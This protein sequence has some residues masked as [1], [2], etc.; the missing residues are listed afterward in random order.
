MTTFEDR[1]FVYVHLGKLYEIGM[2]TDE[3]SRISYIR[4]TGNGYEGC[5]RSHKLAKTIKMSRNGVDITVSHFKG[6]TYGIIAS[7]DGVALSFNEFI[8]MLKFDELTYWNITSI[9]Y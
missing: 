4:M 7:T 5:L 1:C 8:E 9:T 2:L 6:N 3:L